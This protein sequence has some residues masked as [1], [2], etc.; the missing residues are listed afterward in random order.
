MTGLFC[1]S[2]SFS[3]IVQ[4]IVSL[5]NLTVGVLVALA[6]VVFFMGLVRYIRESGDAKGH[7]EAKERIMWSL[8]AIF[9]LVSIWGILTVM[10]TAFFG[11]GGSLSNPVSNVPL[12]TI[13]GG[14]YPQRLLVYN[15]LTDTVKR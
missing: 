4:S 7:A 6:V 1:T 5:I 14:V 3:T 13:N 2:C 8:I 12:Q 9:I 15:S 11:G 10:N